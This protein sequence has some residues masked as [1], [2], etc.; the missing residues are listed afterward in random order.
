ME[1]KRHSIVQIND[2]HEREEWIGC[3]VY[4]DEVKSFGIQGFIKVPTQGSIY[5]RLNFSEIDYI[6]EAVMQIE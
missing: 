3:L 4:V 2:K 5:I 1:I 6:G